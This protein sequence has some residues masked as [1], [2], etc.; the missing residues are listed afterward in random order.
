[1]TDKPVI[2]IAGIVLPDVEVSRVTYS[3]IRARLWRFI[4][5][6][7]RMGHPLHTLLP[8]YAEYGAHIEPKESLDEPKFP[9]ERF[10][11]SQWLA[12]AVIQSTANGGK[13]TDI[14]KCLESLGANLSP[15]EAFFLREG[16]F[17][18]AAI[19]AAEQIC[20]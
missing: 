16:D 17:E 11:G 9:H 7:S 13:G 15:E 14:V 12:A 2:S 10:S 19:A 18:Q 8:F 3:M 6:S 20:W 4:A 1:M 5:R